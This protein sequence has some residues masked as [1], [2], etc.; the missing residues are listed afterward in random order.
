MT[1]MIRLIVKIRGSDINSADMNC[2]IYPSV[3][4]NLD[5]NGGD[6]DQDDGSDSDKDNGKDNDK[7]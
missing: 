7:R 5:G 4:A 3:I 2:C 6:N 1:E